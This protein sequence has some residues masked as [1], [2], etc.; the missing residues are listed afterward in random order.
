M[1]HT[2]ERVDGTSIV[3]LI[4]NK[5]ELPLRRGQL[6]ANTATASHRW[7]ENR[8]DFR[9]SWSRWD[10]QFT[11]HSRSVIDVGCSSS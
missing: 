9:V 10:D 11:H 3:I 1:P 8:F 5:I 7:H 6:R 2:V 4:V